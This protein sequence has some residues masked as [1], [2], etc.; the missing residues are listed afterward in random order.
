MDT[1]LAAVRPLWTWTSI[2]V[3]ARAPPSAAPPPSRLLLPPERLSE[4]STRMSCDPLSVSAG[5][6]E[7]RTRSMSMLSMLP[8][9]CVYT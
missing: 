9:S 1:T 4:P 5:R 7:P 3:S 8:L 2:A 6:A